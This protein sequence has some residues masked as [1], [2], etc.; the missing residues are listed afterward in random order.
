MP[1]VHGEA[2]DEDGRRLRAGERGVLRFRSPTLVGGY[3]GDAAATGK[4]FRDG[5]FYPGDIGSI[6]AG[7]YLVLAGRTDDRLNLG[8]R[9]VDP[10]LIEQA[11]NDHAGVAES[12]ATA[13]PLG[14]LGQMTLVAVVVR[15]PG[16][17]VEPAELIDWCAARVGRSLAPAVVAFTDALP[18]NENGKIRRGLL[19]RSV[20]VVEK[21][22]GEA[23]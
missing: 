11:L 8:G 5:W 2:I 12:A 9:K 17:Q 4:S 18:R 21:R 20:R 19:A 13:V 22:S 23:A 14:E 16:T 10:G 1:W 7:G 15:R 6:D 3:I